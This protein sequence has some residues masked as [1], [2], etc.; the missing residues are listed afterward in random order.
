LRYP[1]QTVPGVS[2]VAS[3][4]GFVKQYQVVVSPDAQLNFH[5]P[6]AKVRAA[7][8]RFNNDVGGCLIEMGET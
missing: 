8:Q 1:L 7:I 4:G 6:L 3:I 2:E 5:V